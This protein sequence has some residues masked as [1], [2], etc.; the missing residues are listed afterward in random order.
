MKLLFG[1]GRARPANQQD[2]HAHD[3]GSQRFHAIM[4]GT[5]TGRAQADR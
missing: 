3:H 2:S 4:M 5:V 1:P